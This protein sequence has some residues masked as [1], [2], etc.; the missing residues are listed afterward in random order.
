[1]DGRLAILRP[2][3][4]ISV[5]S[6]RC[7]DDNEMLCAMELSLRLRRFTSSEDR[8]RSARSVGQCLTHSATGA[9]EKG[10]GVKMMR[11]CC[12]LPLRKGI[13]FMFFLSN[14]FHHVGV[15]D[16]KTDTDTLKH[17]YIWRLI[18]FGDNGGLCKERLNI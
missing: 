7:S 1:M 17:K 10:V 18:H 2:F 14:M 8:T 4:S 12:K 15:L 13:Y 16:N 11:V 9:S 5:K 3:N 6:G